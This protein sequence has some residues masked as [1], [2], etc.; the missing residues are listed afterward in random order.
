MAVWT[1][2]DDPNFYLNSL[3][4]F[5]MPVYEDLFGKETMYQEVCLVYNDPGAE[6]PMIIT[7]TDPILI[8]TSV[9]TLAF[10]NQTLFHLSHEMM[11]YAFR[12]KRQDKN[13]VLSWFEEIVCEAMSLYAL[14]YASDHWTACKLSTNDPTYFRYMQSYFDQEMNKVGTNGFREC[15]TIRQM[16]EYETIAESDRASHRNERNTLCKEFFKDPGQIKS[17]LNYSD[18]RTEPHRLLIDFDRWCADQPSD[19]IRFVEK[20][21]PCKEE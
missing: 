11:H 12:Q 14:Q 8:R 21:Q 1:V 4:R 5:I 18:Y 17:L 13:D 9:D 2:L 19:L 16:A 20:L 7:N 6:C 3:L 10:W 15:K